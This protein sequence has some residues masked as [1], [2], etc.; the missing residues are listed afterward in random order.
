MQ[1]ERHPPSG[2]QALER[3]TI[4]ELNDRPLQGNADSGGTQKRDGQCHNE[5]KVQLRPGEVHSRNGHV[6]S[7]RTDVQPFAKNRLHDIGRVSPDDHDLAVSHIDDTHQS[8]GNRQPERHEQENAAETNSAKTGPKRING[9]SMRINGEKRV[10][11]GGNDGWFL[12]SCARFRKGGLY[13]IIARNGGEVLQFGKGF[14]FHVIGFVLELNEGDGFAQG[15]FHCGVLLGGL[16]QQQGWKPFRFLSHPQRANGE[17]SFG[18]IGI[19]ECLQVEHALHRRAEIAVV[20]GSIEIR[21]E[22]LDGEPCHVLERTAIL[23][24]E[25]SLFPVSVFHFTKLDGD[26]LVPGIFVKIDGVLFP[27]GNQRRDFGRRIAGESSDER[28]LLFVVLLNNCGGNGLARRVSGKRGK[29][30]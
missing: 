4:E 6:D 7:E 16:A 14:R 17:D 22:H 18:R 28:G 8:E 23:H 15:A 21:S 24:E 19:Y 2:E 1:N 11:R 26:H 25:G 29:A 3:T 5:V 13:E 27:R 10:V 30:G 12:R 20:P 9:G